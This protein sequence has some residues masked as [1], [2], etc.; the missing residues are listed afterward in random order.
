[1]IPVIFYNFPKSPKSTK[2]VN[3]AGVTFQCELIEDTSIINPSIK[4]KCAFSQIS[5]KNYCYIAEFSRYY[6]ITNIVYRLGLWEIE[7]SEDTLGSNKTEIGSSSQ[8]VTRSTSDY[9]ETIIDT[10]YET[11]T[12]LLRGGTTESHTIFGD[13][14]DVWYVVGLIG[15]VVGLDPQTRGKVYNGSVVYYCMTHERLDRMMEF[16]LSSQDFNTHFNIPNGEISEPL[17]KQLINPL[18]YIHSIKVIPFEP[19]EK[20]QT[21]YVQLGFNTFLIPWNDVYILGAY[22]LNDIPLANGYVGQYDTQLELEV[23]PD[24]NTKGSW[25]LSDPI[26]RYLLRIPIWGDI[27][28]PCNILQSQAIKYVIDNVTTIR[29]DIRT[30]YDVSTGRCTLRL[31]VDNKVTWFYDETKDLSVNIPFHQAIQNAQGFEQ[32]QLQMASSGVNAVGGFLGDIASLNLGSAI[33]RF[34]GTAQSADALIDSAQNANAV[35]ISGTGSQGAIYS[36]HRLM[37]IPRIEW[38]FQRFV[39]EDRQNIGRPLMQ[40]RT[41]NT[42]SGYIQCKNANFSSSAFE[43]ENNSIINYMNGGFFYE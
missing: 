10:A 40:K 20:V 23:H 26:S 36:F 28:I 3:V 38:Y 16:L 14:V 37:T 41:I 6:F 12:N 21:S 4:L 7:L 9:D 22:D 39:G 24:Y 32:A 15:G 43:E 35:H 5:D 27:D 1:M 33:K 2:Q 31:S 8:Y 30:L 11:K 19:S 34:F 17:A 13:T 18:Q 25:V 29:L 42:L